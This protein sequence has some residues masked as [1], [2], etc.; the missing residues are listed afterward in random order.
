MRIFYIASLFDIGLWFSRVGHYFK[1]TAAASFAL[2]LL[3]DTM[4][5]GLKRFVKFF[6]GGLMM[7]VSWWILWRFSGCFERFWEERDAIVLGMIIHWFLRIV[8]MMFIKCL[9]GLIVHLLKI[10]LFLR[11]ELNWLRSFLFGGMIHKF[12]DI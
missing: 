7:M 9:F 3:L 6:V 11:C 1:F 10:H 8:V 12:I 2:L 5:L 4:R